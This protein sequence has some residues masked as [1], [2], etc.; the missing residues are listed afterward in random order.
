MYYDFLKV[1][2][3][4]LVYRSIIQ[5]ADVLNVNFCKNMY[6]ASLVHSK[7]DCYSEHMLYE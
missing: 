5:F 2:R 7:G 6:N 4:Q 3:F 1:V